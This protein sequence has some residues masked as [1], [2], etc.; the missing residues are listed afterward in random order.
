M[1]ESSHPDQFDDVA[2]SS[3]S[4][5]AS[6]ASGTDST[7]RMWRAGAVVQRQPWAFIDCPSGTRGKAA[8][9][10]LD[11]SLSLGQTAPAY[12]KCPGQ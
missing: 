6:T 2:R 12:R 10:V 3:G 1:F 5:K 4:V 11:G 8:A 7:P 9:N